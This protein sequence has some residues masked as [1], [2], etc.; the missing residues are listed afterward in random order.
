M[1]FIVL[2]SADDV[3]RLAPNAT[4]Q[5]TAGYYCTNSDGSDY[6]ARPPQDTQG[7]QNQL[8]LPGKSDKVSGGIAPATIRVMLTLDYAITANIMAGIR[9]GYVLNTYPGV[10]ASN[11]GKT[12]APIHAEARFTYVIGKDALAKKGLAPYVF[13]AGGASEWDA[14]VNVTVIE[15]GTNS[16]KN[17]QAWNVA[18]PGFASLGGGLRY[19]FTPKFAG[20]FGPRF[21]L[22]FGSTGVTPSISPE[23]GVAIGF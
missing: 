4:P 21:N 2:P 15:K 22:A 13:V 8:I 6:P 23:L 1:D 19:G 20:R 12:F 17:V 18:G 7:A 3:C 11:E 14:E 9:F 16:N 10:A 5:N